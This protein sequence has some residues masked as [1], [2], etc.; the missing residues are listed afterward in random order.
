[1]LSFSGCDVC[2]LL[3]GHS[4]LY[5]SMNTSFSCEWLLHNLFILQDYSLDM[6]TL[7]DEPRKKGRVK[8]MKKEVFIFA[9]LVGLVLV[10]APITPQ[11][12]ERINEVVPAESQAADPCGEKFVAAP[13]N[14]Y[15]AAAESQAV[16]RTGPRFMAGLSNDYMA[17]AESQVVDRTGTPWLASKK[18][19][20]VAC[21]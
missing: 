9:V 1:M 11:A 19:D 5:L 18:H 8:Q 7:R 6:E 10:A 14:A 13:S 12:F 20:L 17:A 15:M 2:V 4:Q 21:R 3:A 16:D